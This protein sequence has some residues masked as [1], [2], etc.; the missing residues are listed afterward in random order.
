MPAVF[1]YLKDR[2][3]MILVGVTHFLVAQVENKEV[4]IFVFALASPSPAVSL[5]MIVLMK[6]EKQINSCKSF[7]VFRF[8]WR[9]KLN[10]T[11]SIESG[12]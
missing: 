2:S 7:Y 3:F 4:G 11:L 5:G 8:S 9:M 6:I 10:V 12:C 1:L